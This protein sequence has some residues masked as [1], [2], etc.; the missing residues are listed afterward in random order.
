MRDAHSRII[1]MSCLEAKDDLVELIKSG[2]IP[3]D[4]NGRLK[5]DARPDAVKRVIL[6]IEMIL[7]EV[8]TKQIAVI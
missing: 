5:K 8:L 3:K 7:R 4:E 1:E 2:N 6:P